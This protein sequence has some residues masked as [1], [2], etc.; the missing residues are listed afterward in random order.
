MS[1]QVIAAHLEQAEATRHR[2]VEDRLHDENRRR[3]LS[4]LAARRDDLEKALNLA[5]SFSTEEREKGRKPSPNGF[6]RWSE[7]FLVVGRLLRECDDTFG[8]LNLQVRLKE[9][10]ASGGPK[11]MVFACAMLTSAAEQTAQKV[12][13]N[14]KKANRHRDV[15]SF[16]LW[17]P[18]ILDNLWQPYPDEHGMIRITSPPF[19]TSPDDIQRAGLAFGCQAFVMPERGQDLPEANATEDSVEDKLTLTHTE[20]FE[21][22]NWKGITYHFSAKQREAFEAL[23]DAHRRNVNGVSTETLTDGKRLRDVFRKKVKVDG[24]LKSIDHPCWNVLIVPVQGI[25]GMFRLAVN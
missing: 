18:Y 22:V 19:G 23:F 11:E 2:E 6:K 12:S 3:Q 10:V 8:H 4:D 20:N 25:K 24:K 7:R 14:L 21:T 1:A 17:L 15:M 16:I 13:S 9:A 5:Y